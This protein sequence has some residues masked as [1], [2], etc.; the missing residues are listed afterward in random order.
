MRPQRTTC[1]LLAVHAAIALFAV[2]CRSSGRTT[3]THPGADLGA[4]RRVAVLPFSTV[5]TDRT[6]GEKVERVF[7]V[8]LLAMG[9]VEVV[10]PGDVAR[11][12][13][14]EKLGPAETLSAGELQRVGRALGADGLFLGQV[15]DFTQRVAGSTPAPEVTIQLR[16][17]EVS[18]GTTAW[19]ST[20]SRSGAGV[21]SRLFGV[22][23]DSLTEA[24]RQLVRK[25]LKRLIK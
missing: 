8:E 6:P 13:T 18:S 3:Y 23:G 10:E 11:L 4:I 1:A 22:G 15:I 2:G 17:V 21:G 12:F 20:E 24:A 19:S 14:A 9:A 16:L 5:G 25:Q 7:L